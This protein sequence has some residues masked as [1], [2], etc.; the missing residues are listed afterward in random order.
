MRDTTFI[1][2]LSCPISGDIRYV[3]KS[4]SPKGR[5][6]KHKQM[7]DNNKSKNLWINSLIIV[8]LKPT[9]AILDEVKISEWKDKE[10]FYITKFKELGCELFN[11]TNGSNGLNFGNQTSFNGRNAIKIISLNKDGSH[12]K[13][14]NS[15]KEAK[16]QYGSGVNSAL[17]GITK[18]SHGFIWMYEDSYNKLSSNELKLIV[19][20]ANINMSKY[21][22][23]NGL[24][25]HQFK[26][27]DNPINKKE[28]HQYTK[29]GVFIK[30]WTSVSEA[31]MSFSGRQCSHISSC[32]TGKRKIAFGFKW[33]YK[34]L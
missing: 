4:N 24:K 11:V 25:Y 16:S 26:K 13:T 23:K 20:N 2:T 32:A 8:G 22:W 18:T 1:Y 12:N 10:K 6:S 31:S 34:L 17:H 28:V 27:G 21:A 19:E 30:T 29:D 15:V 7:S 33:S 3:G 9:L 5:Y 14:F